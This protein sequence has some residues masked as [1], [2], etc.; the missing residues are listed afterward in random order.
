MCNIIKMLPY[1]GCSQMLHVSLKTEIF[2][3]ANPCCLLSI[4]GLEEY[5]THDW[6][7]ATSVQRAPV[8][9]REWGLCLES[10][11][12][13]LLGGHEFMAG[14]FDGEV[15]ALSS[16]TS[17]MVLTMST[18]LSRKSF[19]A[20]NNFE[21][22]VIPIEGSR[23]MIHLCWQLYRHWCTFASH[24]RLCTSNSFENGDFWQTCPHSRPQNG[25]FYIVRFL[26][27]GITLKHNLW[28]TTYETRSTFYRLNVCNTNLHL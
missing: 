23:L 28:V 27:T 6:R 9:W 5:S 21:R 17:T 15:L 13:L 24:W 8:T 18:I 14:V 11:L 20:R 3:I 26:A 2:F 10:H 22:D 7:T 12:R 25:Y 1:N 16:I 19:G 4:V